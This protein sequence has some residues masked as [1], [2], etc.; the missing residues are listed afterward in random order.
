MKAIFFAILCL[1]VT[2]VTVQGLFLGGFG[3][4]ALKAA[5]VGYA[6]GRGGGRGGYRGG[7]RRRGGYGHGYRHRYGRSI[8]DSE[9]DLSNDLIVEAELQDTDDCAKMLICQ[10]NAKTNEEPLDT[11]E[12]LIKSMFGTDPN[13]GLDVTKSS[14]VFD[15]AATIGQHAGMKQCTLLYGR[16][17]VPYKQLLNILE[18]EN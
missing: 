8:E 11:T 13:G 9:E 4:V 18:K 10:L 1:A 2:S 12:T 5:L 15:L 7:Y 16:C 6:I 3:L 14:V 17:D